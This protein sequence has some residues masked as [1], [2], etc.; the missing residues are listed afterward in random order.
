MNRF[1]AVNCLL[2]ALFATL[3]YRLFDLGIFQRPYLLQVAKKQ[4]QVVI[5]LEAKRGNIL[6]RHGKLLATTIKSPSIYAVPR[7]L[8]RKNKFELVKQISEILDLNPSWVEERLSQD[9]SFV[10]LKRKVTQDEAEAILG[11]GNP[12]LLVQNEFKRFYPHKGELAHAIGFC[13]IDNQGLEGLELAHDSYLRGQNGQLHSKR[14]ALG[15]EIS[16]LE[17]K[18]I[19]PVNGRNVI[20]YADEFIQHIV[21]RE[22]D[23][24][25][26][27]WRA[28]G[29]CALV[30]DP[31]TGEIL[32]IANRPSFDANDYKQSSAEFRRNR[33]LT[34]FYEPGSIFK[35]ITLTAAL[36]EGK[37]KLDDTIFCQNGTWYVSAKRVIHDVH[38][39]G[40]L[41]VPE[42]LIKSSN[43]GT[44]KIAKIIGEKALYDYI[45]LFGFGE[46]SGID[47]QGEVSGIVHP[48]NQWSKAS[49]TSVPYGQEVA[50]T[51]LQMLR[52]LSVIAN[53]G[54]LV[55]PQLMKEVRDEHGVVIKERIPPVKQKIIDE[56]ITTTMRDILVRVVDEGTGQLAKIKGVKVAGKT[57]TSQKLNPQGGYSH[58]NFISSFMGFA[59]AER[60]SLAMIIMIDDPHPS[61]YGGTV[62]APVFKSV[63]EEALLYLGYTSELPAEEKARFQTPLQPPIK[64]PQETKT[65][66]SPILHS[67]AS[68]QSQ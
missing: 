24:A 3:A 15:R 55:K 34:D 40:K 56:K 57:G 23:K 64:T 51:S 28:K 58:S 49:I 21:E 63:M 14:D 18:Y 1:F 42:V 36:S 12:N 37:V 17:S 8:S 61:Y 52:A 11:L 50:A 26:T 6:D 27:K 29:A 43:I 68:H 5:E 30:M 22:L 10:W 45:K 2:L 9:K 60:P 25:F 54:Y 38:P 13:N 20:L 16:T 32:A 66:A 33:C 59:P 53:G 47:L 48:L 19:P 31:H 62:A 67:L 46:L 39:Y 41:T 44:V 4:H 7:L 35:V 65:P